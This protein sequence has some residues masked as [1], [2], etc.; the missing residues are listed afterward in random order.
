MRITMLIISL[1]AF[2]MTG[3]QVTDKMAESNVQSYYN[4]TTGENGLIHTQGSTRIKYNLSTG[5][6]ELIIIR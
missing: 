1:L 3:C 5:T 2:S 6:T 4:F